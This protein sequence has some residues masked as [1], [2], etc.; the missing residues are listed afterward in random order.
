MDIINWLKYISCKY[1]NINKLTLY[2]RDA[3]YRLQDEELV[4]PIIKILNNTVNLT[5]YF[6]SILPFSRDGGSDE[7]YVETLEEQ[8]EVVQSSRQFQG[9]NKLS[10]SHIVIP[11]I[12]IRATVLPKIISTYAPTNLAHL[13]LDSF[14]Q[15]DHVAEIFE[16]LPTTVENLQL[17]VEDEFSEYTDWGEMPVTGL[18]SLQLTLREA[19]LVYISVLDYFT[20]RVI[21]APVINN[22]LECITSAFPLLEDFILHGSL[23][24]KVRFDGPLKLH[25]N[26]QHISLNYLEVDMKPTR[27]YTFNSQMDHKIIATCTEYDWNLDYFGSYDYP[28]PPENAYQ[29][30]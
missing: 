23:E 29:I 14:L 30:D 13:D 15:A 27:S 11:D 17:K 6:N 18:N 9:L 4:Q 26:E 20:Q 1:S 16:C 10:T 12:L 22:F 25:F 3:V 28:L 24:E 2:S 7:L 8:L 21:K 5:H 19:K